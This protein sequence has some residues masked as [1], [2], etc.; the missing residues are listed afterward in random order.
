MFKS[1]V[2]SEFKQTSKDQ[3]S[4]YPSS[5]SMI[6]FSMKHNRPKST[7]TQWGPGIGLPPIFDAAI[8]Y[9]K[10]YRINDSQ[11]IH[12]TARYDNLM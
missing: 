4:L 11:R 5:Q 9:M 10:S 2:E 6:I 3:E 7:S 8:M 1:C 12:A